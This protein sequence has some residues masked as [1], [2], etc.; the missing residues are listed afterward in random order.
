MAELSAAPVDEA[1]AAP[2]L[3]QDLRYVGLA[4]RAISFVVDAA[5]ITVVDVIV[6]VAA[7]LILSFLH[8]PHDLRVILTVLGAIGYVL[9]SIVYFAAFWAST[10]QTPGARIL[11]IRVATEDGGRVHARWALLRCIGVLLAALPLFAGFVPILF[12]SRRRG[13]QDWLARTVVVEA[14]GPSIAE[15][16]RAK[17]RAIYEASRR[18][19]PVAGE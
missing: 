11:Q 7:A 8:I 19:P 5:L 4:T 2:A 6:G 13:F 18:P 17:K 10:G 3:A 14:P 1:P 9:G 16:S 15:V 12:N